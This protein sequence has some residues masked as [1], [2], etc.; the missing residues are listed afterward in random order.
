MRCQKIKRFEGL[1]KHFHSLPTSIKKSILKNLDLKTI[2]LICELCLN[3]LKKRIPLNTTTLKQ[4]RRHKTAIKKLSDN[5][6]SLRRKKHILN[7]RGSGFF[8]PLLFSAI[9]PLISRLIG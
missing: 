2:H 7:Q 1:I 8:L 9:T 3:I 4:I 5:T 6:V